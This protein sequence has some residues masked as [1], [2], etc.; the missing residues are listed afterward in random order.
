MPKA[1]SWILV[2]L[3]VAGLLTLSSCSKNKYAMRLDYG[4]AGYYAVD[5]AIWDSYKDAE[6]DEIWWYTV[7]DATA[8]LKV[9]Y[10]DPGTSLP[11][12]PAGHAVHLES[13]SVTW[14][15]TPKL[16]KTTGAL[17]FLVPLDI[18]GGTEVTVPIMVMPGISKDTVGVLGDLIGD[19]GSERN[20]FV[21]QITSKATIEVRGRDVV[22]DHEVAAT[23]ELT[24]VFAD[25]VNPNK[26][27]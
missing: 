16:P 7:A 9:T 6:G 17:D 21:G 10:V 1:K 15:G 23:T 2:V 3:C 27:H 19:P 5:V 14:K 4:E 18:S 13:Y 8:E 20:T 24:G 11:A 26:A 12:Y 25:Y 22:D